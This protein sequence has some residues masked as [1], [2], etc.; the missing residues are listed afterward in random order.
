[1]TVIVKCG[2]TSY[3]RLPREIQRESEER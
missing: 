1:M 2:T 3:S